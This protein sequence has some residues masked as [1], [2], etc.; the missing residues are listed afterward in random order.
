MAAIPHVKIAQIAR[1]A[2]LEQEQVQRVFDVITAFLEEGTQVRIGEFGNF[3]PE[4]VEERPVKSPVVPGGVA[5][6]KPGRVIRFSMAKGLRRQWREEAEA[7]V[8]AK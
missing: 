2:K 5:Q 7:A 8:G 6:V 3:T 1:R 4:L